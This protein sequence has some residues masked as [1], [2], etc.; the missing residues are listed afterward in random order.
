MGYG[1]GLAWRPIH[2][3]IVQ[4][5][6]GHEP[7]EQRI[8]ADV[9]PHTLQ[10]YSR[11]GKKLSN[12]TQTELNKEIQLPKTNM[13]YHSSPIHTINNTVIY[14]NFLQR[15]THLNLTKVLDSHDEASVTVFFIFSS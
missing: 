7:P 9:W 3:S 4:E 13:K 15:H 8:S 14:I 5:E 1:R 12:I 10:K 11:H 6:R 2:F